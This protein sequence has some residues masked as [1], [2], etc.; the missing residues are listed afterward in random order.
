LLESWRFIQEDKAALYRMMLNVAPA[1][2]TPM[3][4]R[5]AQG[6][7]SYIKKLFRAIEDIVPWTRSNKMGDLHGKVKPGE[8]RVI[9]DEGESSKDPLF[10]GAKVSR[11]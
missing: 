4:K 9:L 5:S 10:K 7:Q 3:D 11:G 6:M 1:A 2:R 8:I